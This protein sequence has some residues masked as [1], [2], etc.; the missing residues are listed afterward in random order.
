MT[1]QSHVILDLPRLNVRP[2][3]GLLPG[4]LASPKHGPANSHANEASK[5]KGWEGS[6]PVPDEEDNPS[7]E[8]QDTEELQ[9]DPRAMPL[10]RLALGLGLGQQVID[11]LL[12]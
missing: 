8:Y 10:S 12:R 3:F 7:N 5:R 6:G 4:S 2:N 11:D 1:Q 9:G